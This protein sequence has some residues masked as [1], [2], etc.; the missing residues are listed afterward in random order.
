MKT[1][2]I[3]IRTT[4]V[5]IVLTGLI[6]PYVM[7]GLAQ[8]MFPWRANGSLVT[9]EQGQVVGSELIAQGFVNPAYFQPRP[10]AAGEKGYDAT[11][12]SGSNLGPTSKKLQDRIND[13]LKRLKAENP[14]AIG[15]VPAELMTASASG[16]DP[17]LSPEAM[18]WQAP[19]VAKAR[20][21]ALDRVRAVVDANIEGRTFGILGEPRVNV[22]LVNLALDRQFGRLVT[23]PVQTK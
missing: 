1:M 8:V 18:L 2:S 6:Y 21:V 5:T 12:S 16:L 17:H 15:P 11:S 4:I 20:N 13:D 9:D 14:E 23:Q 19:R 3:A 10:S 22:L 7:T